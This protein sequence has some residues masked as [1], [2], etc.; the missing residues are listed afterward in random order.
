[1]PKN[2]PLYTCAVAGEGDNGKDNK[3][4]KEKRKK[5]TLPKQIRG[6]LN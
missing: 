4:K 1:M 2:L 5:K 3:K 6:K